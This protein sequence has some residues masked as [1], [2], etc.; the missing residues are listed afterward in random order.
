[1]TVLVTGFDPFA[2]ASANPSAELAG[3]LSDIA[4]T[5]VLPVEFGLL[6][7]L[8]GDLLEEAR[9]SAVVCLGLS[10]ASRG[11][12]FERV[13]VNLVDARI[14]D[15]AGVQPV[16]EQVVPGGPAGY[17]TT[18]P[19]KAMVRAAHAAGVPGE[20]SLSAGSYAC[21]ALMYLAL[22]AAAMLPERSRPRCGFVHVPSEPTLSLDAQ[23]RGLRAALRVV[24]AD[25]EHYPAGSLG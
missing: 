22:H 17:F 19:V 15:N 21:N 25:E 8:L 5:A 16:D 11:L 23:E 7:R 9:P 13:A 3:R 14:A 6:G 18:L 4:V 10:E 24:H 20:L 12:T 1:M 2:G